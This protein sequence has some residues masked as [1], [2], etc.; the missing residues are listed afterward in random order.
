M[1]YFQRLDQYC[2]EKVMMALLY[3][4]IDC[5]IS[6]MCQQHSEQNHLDVWVNVLLTAI[7]WMLKVLFVFL[8]DKEM[9]QC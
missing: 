4:M 2:D 9:M 1:E 7:F 6:E 5:Q 8:F 3:V